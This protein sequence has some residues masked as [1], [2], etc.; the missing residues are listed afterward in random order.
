M[1]EPSDA[2]NELDSS[3][4]R[5]NNNKKRRSS[6]IRTAATASMR[7]S[8]NS[9]TSRR[10]S[11]MDEEEN[12]YNYRID[13]EP[14]LTDLDDDELQEER[15]E[16]VEA[17]YE[18]V[19][20]EELVRYQAVVEDDDEA[21]TGA[22]SISERA[23]KAGARVP[24][25][26]DVLVDQ[27]DETVRLD[28]LLFA[29]GHTLVLIFYRGKWDPHAHPDLLQLSQPDTLD[30]FKSK[31]ARIVAVSPTRPDGT[32]FMSSKSLLGFPVVS[33]VG[34][35]LARK[36]RTSFPLSP[37]RLRT[38]CGNGH[39][40]HAD[41]LDD[42]DD[43]DVL[44]ENGNGSL[45]IPLPAMYVVESSGTVLLRWIQ[46]IDGDA[47]PNLETILAAIPSAPPNSQQQQPQQE[48]EE[49]E[50]GSNAKKT[51]KKIAAATPSAPNSQKKKFG[52]GK[53][54]IKT[55]R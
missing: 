6:S 25:F 18:E 7:S 13:D 40:N 43:L 14:G 20:E 49:A 53:L 36:F 35:R 29:E 34:N 19:S 32:V 8:I 3:N 1:H 26:P 16:F 31:N 47:R 45:E 2:T 41:F 33:D 54:F 23:L 24:R 50:D 46:G 44:F 11:A 42:F 37:A 4:A 55:K 28:N 17:L 39:D 38:G 15:S 21:T 52:M 27:D 9:T 51:K 48:S 5:I 22:Q 12:Y 10:L 30:K